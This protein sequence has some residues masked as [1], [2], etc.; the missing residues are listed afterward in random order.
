MYVLIKIGLAENG[1]FPDDYRLV[2]L[3]LRVFFI[4]GGFVWRLTFFQI[5]TDPILFNNCLLE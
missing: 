5:Q 4:F 3:S 1:V 2:F